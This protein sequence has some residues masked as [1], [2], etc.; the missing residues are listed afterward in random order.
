MINK[1]KEHFGKKLF[2]KFKKRLYKTKKNLELNLIRLFQDKKNKNILFNELEE[3]LIISDI[4]IK[5]TK[6][7]IS[8]LKEYFNKNNYIDQV[9]LYDKLYLEMKKILINVEKN[10]E[11][12]KKLFVILIVGV[13][14]VGKT[15]T[16]GK[17]AYKYKKE[18]KKIMLAA[19][20]TF[21]PGA[22]EQLKIF[23][24]RNC[25]PVIT[26]KNSK[27]SAS[28]V[29]KA[30]KE[31]KSNNVD[32][33]IIDTAGRLQNKKYLMNELKKI[34]NII[35][36]FDIDAPHETMLILDASTGQNAINQTYLFNK[37]IKITGITF[38]KLDGTAKGGM[39]FA[40]SDVFCIPIRYLSVGEN[41]DDLRVFNAKEFIKAIFIKK[42]EI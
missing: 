17:L 13:N 22:Y 33:L 37:A 15:T 26:K 9:K 20:D 42:K 35:K 10:I 27:D 11:I 14:G 40:I 19:G 24:D 31:A 38:T 1:N 8:N 4:G 30:L 3:R 28:V 39:I 16:I 18:N 2:I 32:I 23:G 41:I 6:K 25:I 7:I 5:T 34:V 12:K 29:F 36:K 21:R